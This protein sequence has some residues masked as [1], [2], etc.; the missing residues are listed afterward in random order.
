MAKNKQPSQRQ[1]RVGE[2]LRHA[3]SGILGRGKLRNPTLRNV[4]ITVTEVRTSPDLKNATAF[5]M[6]LGGEAADEIVEALG[7]AAPY[8]RS[9]VARE[10]ELRH[11]PRLQFEVDRS[12][13]QADHIDSLL[14][15]PQV[16]RDLDESANET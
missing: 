9:T 4:S 1:L 11:V 5:V 10:V 2:A 16:A 6:P 15:Q 14:R 13:G 12:F 3:L 8:L 7:K